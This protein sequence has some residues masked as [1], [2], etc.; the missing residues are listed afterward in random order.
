MQRLSGL[1]R[2]ARSSFQIADQ[3]RVITLWSRSKLRLGLVRT[4]DELG[5]VGLLTLLHDATVERLKGTDIVRIKFGEGVDL[6]CRDFH[7]SLQH[8]P[9]DTFSAGWSC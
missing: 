8:K 5:V 4:H 1:Q 7:R 2:R 3:P 9:R 6:L